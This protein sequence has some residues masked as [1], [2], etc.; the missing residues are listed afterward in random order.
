[1]QTSSFSGR[2][3][4]GTRIYT[5]FLIVLLLLCV[6]AGMGYR[7][8]MNMSEV[9]GRYAFISDASLKV[10]GI[11]RDV[12]QMR[13]NVLSFIS[14]GDPKVQVTIQGLQET[15]GKD[16]REVAAIV[17]DPERRALMERMQKLLQ[18]YADNFVK[19]AD[20]RIQRDKLVNELMEPLGSK[21]RKA[22]TQIIEETSRDN[23]TDAS[24]LAA[25]AQESLLLA[26]LN[27]SRFLSTP[28]T[29]L[30]DTARAQLGDFVKGL[31]ALTPALRNPAHQRLLQDVREDTARYRAS[32]DQVVT[33]VTSV[34][35]LAFEVMA[36]DAE[37]FAKLADKT[38]ELQ[39]SARNGLTEELAKT[40]ST[41]EIATIVLAA[42]SL[43]IGAFFAWIVARSIVVPVLAM[44]GTMTKLASGDLTVM[45]P[46][47]GNKDEVGEMARAVLVFKDNAVEKKRLDEAEA[48]RLE[49]ERAAEQAQRE[50]EQ[51]IGEEIASL[52]DSVS[53]G[54]LTRRID[55]V[56]KD[57]FYKTMSEGINRLTD[58]VEAVIAD[59]AEV[60][61]ALAAG[62]LSK[63]VT[64]DYQGAFQR[65]K[66]DVNATSIK[67]SEIVGQIT[68][69]AE[70]IASAS[71]EVST[72]S[73]DLSD[74]TEQQASSLEETAASMEELGATVRSN[75]DNAQRANKMADE[76]R[77][78]AENGGSVAESAV[79]AMK[80][81]EDASRKITDIIGVIDEI[82]FQTNLLALNAAVEAARAGDAGRGFAVVAQEVRNL[83]QRSA[84]ASKEIKALILDSDGQVREGVD[85]V[86]KAG[87]ALEGIVSGVQQVAS[88]ISDM[89]SASTE[90]AT[91]LDEINATVAQM[92]EMTQKN[93]ALVEETTAAA[94]AMAGQAGDLKALVG[95]F[96]LDDA[97]AAALET[98]WRA[99][100]KHTPQVRATAKA[101]KPAPKPTPRA[102]AKAGAPEPVGALKRA[103]DD[104][105]W[106]EF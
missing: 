80:R 67:L 31:D 42:A 45:V 1:M 74:R 27:V 36:P 93:A 30:T 105:D 15:L 55:L 35:R 58:T 29:E 87:N 4:V 91:A 94:Q 2:F 9:S 16:L 13:R 104:G 59:L 22:L 64:R 78:A 89:A 102:P 68:Q 19:L 20:A 41:S 52:I 21:I 66:D 50:R 81:I 11:D 43:L 73:T 76:A 98:V 37:E 90:Q 23:E 101:T 82:A 69:A 38:V 79:G 17:T 62:D 44:T 34:N 54:N 95:F 48:A 106:T 28:K 46:A 61:S 99:Q 47:T 25:R 14:S 63:R 40:V 8:L 18:A 83:A 5:G 92:D 49:A 57:G 96:R 72:G 3:K 12:S 56:G 24:A 70:T 77:K 6:V 33:A 10:V 51:A 85:L 53:K 26:R 7:T 86:K 65:V 100:P 103:K 39:A 75:A 71:A 88:L 84:Q 97:T 60:L 32:I